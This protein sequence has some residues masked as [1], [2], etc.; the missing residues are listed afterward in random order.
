MQTL[1]DLILE[2]DVYKRFPGLFV[3][4]ELR[5]ARKRGEI[6]YYPRGR[7]TYYTEADLVAYIKGRRV[8]CQRMENSPVDPE[9][10]V[11]RDSSRSVNTGSVMSLAGRRST[12]TSMTPELER[13]AENRLNS[14]T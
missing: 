9:R 4:D 10:V 13:L 6:A 12:A 7:A 1:A 14:E 2:T 3:E 5:L 11:P 8:E